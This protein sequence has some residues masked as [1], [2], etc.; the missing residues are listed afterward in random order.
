MTAFLL[1]AQRSTPHYSK[2]WKSEQSAS[3]ASAEAGWQ[4]RHKRRGSTGWPQGLEIVSSFQR[5]HV[6]AVKDG[7]VR[8]H[9]LPIIKGVEIPVRCIRDDG[10]PPP[11]SSSSSFPWSSSSSIDPD[12]IGN[13]LVDA[14]DGQAY[15]MVTI[16]SQ[17]WMAENLRY[18]AEGNSGCRLMGSKCDS[19]GLFYSFMVAQTACPEG[20]HLPSKGEYESG[21]SVHDCGRACPQVDFR[22]VFG[23]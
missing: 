3:P 11:E 7:R 4:D 19:Q 14:R 17:T 5:R 18:A 20:W 9:F 13:Y 21:R 15:R 2:R 22:L 16:G 1:P 6:F 23:I 8:H 10:P 12:S